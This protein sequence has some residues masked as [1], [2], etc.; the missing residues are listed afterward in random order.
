MKN[1]FKKLM[2]D[3]RKFRWKQRNDCWSMGIVLKKQK[4]KKKT[5][6]NL[7]MHKWV[8]R[9]ACHYMKVKFINYNKYHKLKLNQRDWTTCMQRWWH[10][11][12]RLTSM[13]DSEDGSPQG[14]NGSQIIK[15]EDNLQRD[16]LAQDTLN[17]N[18]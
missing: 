6:D 9:Y 18:E 13:S 2:K 15:L 4:N 1:A 10:R 17:M 14:I 8:R 11:I 5:D 3:I 7:V 12:A 16:R